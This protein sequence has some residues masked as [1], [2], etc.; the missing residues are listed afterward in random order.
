VAHDSHNIVAVGASDEEIYAAIGEVI[1]MGGG[2]AVVADGQVLDS[3]AL[4]IAGLMSDKPLDKVVAAFESLESRARAIGVK[5]PA[6]FA[7]LSFLALPVIPEL[8]LTD[9]GMV[10]V[11]AFKLI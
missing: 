5:L 2:L 6:P 1:R 10:D 3:L 9:L 8:K 7:A 4:P 11:S